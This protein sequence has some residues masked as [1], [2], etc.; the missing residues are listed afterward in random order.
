MI[1]SLYTR[2]RLIVKGLHACLLNMSMHTASAWFNS[3]Y[4]FSNRREHLCHRFFQV[5]LHPEHCMAST[6]TCYLRHVTQG[7]ELETATARYP[8]I[9]AHHERYKRTLV[10]RSVVLAVRGRPDDT[11]VGGYLFFWK[12]TKI[13]QQENVMQTCKNKKVVYKTGRKVGLYGGGIFLFP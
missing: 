10:P 13:V 4:Y 12:Q 5:M 9:P 8:L 7:M 3:C 2:K 11:C 6:T 1:C